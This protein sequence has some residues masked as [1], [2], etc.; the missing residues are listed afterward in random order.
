MGPGIA[1][2]TVRRV[3]FGS[4]FAGKATGELR[5]NLTIR[6]D[7]QRELLG[8][9]STAMGSVPLHHHD[10]CV[11][12]AE[13]DRPSLCVAEKERLLGSSD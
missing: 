9:E 2:L 3:R 11:C 12:V 8:P 13:C 5:A 7:H 1:G 4:E 10:V 6:F